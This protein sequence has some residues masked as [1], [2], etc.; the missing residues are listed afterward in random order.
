MQSINYHTNT[1]IEPTATTT[2]TIKEANTIRATA[3]KR[4]LRAGLLLATLVLTS[5]GIFYAIHAHNRLMDEVKAVNYYHSL[6]NNQ[7]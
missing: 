2:L 3:Y 1:I 7:N 5:I 6:I 4:G